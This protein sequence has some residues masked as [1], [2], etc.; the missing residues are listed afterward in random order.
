MKQAYF[1]HVN[2]TEIRSWNQQVLS[3]EGK[4]K[5][6]VSCSRKQHTLDGVLI[7]D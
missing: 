6:K 1:V 4:G 2:H 7:H 5:S 3:N